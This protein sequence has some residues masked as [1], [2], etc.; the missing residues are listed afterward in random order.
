[1]LVAAEDD[2]ESAKS[3]MKLRLAV[4]SDKYELRI[5]PKGGHGTGLFG[6]KVDLEDRLEQF[7]A[8]NLA[9]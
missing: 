5:Y 8:R 1:L 6:K 9:K 7:F 3:A 2:A 4:E